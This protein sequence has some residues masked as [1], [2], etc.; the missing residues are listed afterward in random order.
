MY[1]RYENVYQ[2]GIKG[3]P[4]VC[5]HYA[6]KKEAVKAAKETLKTDPYGKGWDYARIIDLKTGSVYDDYFDWQV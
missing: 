5:G 3:D 1:Y 6:S 4:E 2:R